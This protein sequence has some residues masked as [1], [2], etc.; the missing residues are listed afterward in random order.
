MDGG[1]C[2]WRK[3]QG[4]NSARGLSHETGASLRIERKVAGIGHRLDDLADDGGVRNAAGRFGAGGRIHY[5]LPDNS[6][7]A[8]LRRIVAVSASEI[9]RTCFTQSSMARAPVR[10]GL[11]IIL[12]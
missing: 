8:W 9:D 3:I 2:G 10:V 12:L 5:A 7:S 6:T 4:V 11:A 1:S